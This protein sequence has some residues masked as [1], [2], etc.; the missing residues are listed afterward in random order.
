M[1]IKFKE[2]LN[3]P[4]IK[5]Y[6]PKIVVGGPGAWQLENNQARRFS[7]IDCVVVGESE[8]IVGVLF[9]KAVQGKE[10]PKVVQGKVVESEEIPLIKQPP[11][12]GIIEIAR[13]CGRGCDFCVPTLQRYRCLPIRGH[14]ER[15]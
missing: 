2:L 12:D 10:I 9:E 13:G 14:L 7:G 6:Q 5:K 15:S 4:A 3:H 8:K 1:N 11:I